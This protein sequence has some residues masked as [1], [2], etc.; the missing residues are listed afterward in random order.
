MNLEIEQTQL[1]LFISEV[2][3]VDTN[4][5]QKNTRDDLYMHTQYKHTI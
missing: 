2:D 3:V 4:Q 1:K 5:R